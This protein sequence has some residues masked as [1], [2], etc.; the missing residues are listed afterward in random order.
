MTRWHLDEPASSYLI[1]IA[2]GDFTDDPGPLGQRACPIT[3]WTPARPAPAGPRGCGRRP[4]Q[5]DW[6]EDRLGPYPFSS[7]GVVVVDSRSGMET[8][9]MI[10]LGTTDYTTS[11]EVI[12]H[13]M[14]HQW[15]GDEVT[16][17]RLARPLDERGH[18]DVPP[19]RCGRPS[20]T[21]IAV[22]ALMDD[23]ARVE[24]RMRRESGPPA[25]YDPAT[26]GEGNVYYGPALMWDELRQRLGDEEFWSAGAGLA[27]R[28]T[29]T[30]TRR[31][32]TSPSWWSQQTGEDLKPFFDAWL[33]GKT[34]P[35]TT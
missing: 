11:P 28:P 23:W 26:F 34:S 20:T 32:T 9:T 29:R 16:P 31:T 6:I 35:P 1:T 13:E 2:I 15:Y 12:V 17:G 3:Y 18:G 25:D 10:T 24:P 7:L 14:V 33:L 8:Q 19:G 30:A 27:D 22:D 21:G 4:T 5:L